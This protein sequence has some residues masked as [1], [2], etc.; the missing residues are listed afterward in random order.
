MFDKINNL[1]GISV[2]YPN[3]SNKKIGNASQKTARATDS[4]KYN[5]QVSMLGGDTL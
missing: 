3:K 2:K 1:K 5:L 4:G